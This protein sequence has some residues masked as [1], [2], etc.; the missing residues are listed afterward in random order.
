MVAMTAQLSR[1]FFPDAA[2]FFP[3]VKRLAVDLVDGSLR[4][5]HVA[6]LPGHE[7]INVVGLSVG[8]FHIDT[9][10]IFSAAD[11][12][13]AIVM[14]PDQVERQILSPV[15]DVELSIGGFLSLA[16]D[17]FFNS[18][19]DIGLAHFLRLGAALRG[20]CCC[21]WQLLQLWPRMF[22]SEERHGRREE[23]RNRYCDSESCNHKLKMLQLRRFVRTKYFAAVS[24][25]L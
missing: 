10:K 7:E 18:G 13:E 22:C 20:S 6:R 15:L 2:F 5:L 1:H 21:L 9:G 24:D 23:Q 3:I 11:T 17:M 25:G 4:D 19:R 16:A 8:R 14:D 12:R